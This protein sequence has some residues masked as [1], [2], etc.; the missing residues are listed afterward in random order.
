[1]VVYHIHVN[2]VPESGNCTQALGHLDPYIR[3]EAPPC[4]PTNPQACQVGDLSGK[5]GTMNTGTT[6][7]AR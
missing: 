2:P 1:M 3:G 6:F 7:Q 5:Y 4:D